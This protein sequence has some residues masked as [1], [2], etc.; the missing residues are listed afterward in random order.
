LSSSFP[1]GNGLKQG[2]ALSPVL[3][4]FALEYAIREVHETRLGLD[5]YGNYQVLAYAD[6]ANLSEK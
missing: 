5:M 6:D 3:Y 1:V 4:K 2:D